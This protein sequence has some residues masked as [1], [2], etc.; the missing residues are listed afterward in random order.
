MQ[1]TCAAEQECTHE[2][3]ARGG[4]CWVSEREMLGRTS[5]GGAIACQQDMAYEKVTQCLQPTDF[6]SARPD[7]MSFQAN[8]Q[9]ASSLL[10]LVIAGL[11]Q[12]LPKARVL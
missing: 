10:R 8:T 11:K 3:C 4:L 5:E 9:V 6:P 12:Y 2:R 1:G 7:I